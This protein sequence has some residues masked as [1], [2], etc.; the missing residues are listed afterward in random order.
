MGKSQTIDFTQGHLLRK[1]IVF[2][3]P[4][5]ISGLLQT[6]FNGADLIVVGQFAGGDDLAAVGACGSLVNLI[7]GLALGLSVGGNIVVSVFIGAND[8]PGVKKAVDTT[9][10]TAFV[11]GIV[12]MLVGVFGARVFLSAM[13]TPKEILD[14]AVVYFQLYFAGVPASMMYNFCSAILR[15][16]GESKKPLWFLAAAGVLNVLLNLLFVIV[17]HMGAAGVALATALSQYLAA[18][19]VLRELMSTNEIYKFVPKTFA[20]SKSVLKRILSVGIPSGIQSIVFSISNVLIQSS[21][22]GF[23]P[24]V[25]SGN[26]AANNIEGF[27]YVAMNAF[28]VATTT[29]VGQNIGARQYKRIDKILIESG[30]LVTGVGLLLGILV[31]VFGDPLVRLY[32]PNSEAAIAAAR[33]KLLYVAL[34]YFLCGIL[35]VLQGTLKSCGYAVSGMIISLICCCGVRVVWIYT[36]FQYIKTL[37]CLFVLYSITWILAI[38]TFVI[39]YITGAR[40]KLQ[41]KEKQHAVII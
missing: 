1:L 6:F 4:L 11:C 13:D 32:C 24:A 21:I 15:S 2:V 36:V 20:P 18:T 28:S 33:T 10:A 16:S 30:L 41:S 38:V 35:E 5:M 40:K 12:C 8:K 25:V 7:I 27:V 34:P 29:V 37:D 14:K 17:F 23:G 22:N 31:N 19:L 26:A 9:I 39:L 3:I